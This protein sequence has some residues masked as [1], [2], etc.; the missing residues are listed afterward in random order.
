MA[1]AMNP[2]FML[3][4]AKKKTTT[5]FSIKKFRKILNFF[6]EIKTRKKEEEE[7]STSILRALRHHRGEMATREKYK[8]PL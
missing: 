1:A 5:S 8:M 4:K 3:A 7:V 2:P 6:R